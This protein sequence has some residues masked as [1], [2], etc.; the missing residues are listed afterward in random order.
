MVGGDSKFVLTCTHT[1]SRTH[2]HNTHLEMKKRR[3]LAKWGSG[4]GKRKLV[5]FPVSTI[6]VMVNADEFVCGG[7]FFE[8]FQSF[9]VT[10]VGGKRV[11]W[12][13]YK[14]SLVKRFCEYKLF[15]TV[16]SILKFSIRLVIFGVVMLLKISSKVFQFVTKIRILF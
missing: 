15:V 6:K 9:E 8:G 1:C 10:V 5:F 2:T 7:I 14:L 4:L 13:G 12:W 3:W 11:A 16:A